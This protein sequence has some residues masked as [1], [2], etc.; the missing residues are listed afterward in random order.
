MFSAVACGE[1]LTG[2]SGSTLD[3]TDPAEPTPLEKQPQRSY[4]CSGEKG[5]SA[6]C[7]TGAEPG[8]AEPLWRVT[9]QNRVG[10]LTNQSTLGSSGGGA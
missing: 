8:G 5:L 10:E 2:L 9:D 7:R 6:D 1:T 3:Q 4:S